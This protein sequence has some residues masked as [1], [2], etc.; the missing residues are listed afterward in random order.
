MAQA[1]QAVRMTLTL[2]LPRDAS[3]VPT[4]RH[5]VGSSLAEL[6]VD[7]DCRADI[8]GALS[9]ASANVMRHSGPGDEFEATSEMNET[10]D[11]IPVV[12]TGHGFDFASPGLGTAEITAEQGR[13]IQLMRALVDRVRFLSKPEEGTIVHLEKVL[14]FTDRSR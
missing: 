12:D 2:C 8:E 7:A 13:G 4:V 6:G 1:A 14:E 3:T 10:E 5:I 9:E 11:V